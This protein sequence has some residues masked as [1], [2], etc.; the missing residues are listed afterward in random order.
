MTKGFSNWKRALEIFLQH[1]NSSMHKEAS[2]KIK[3]MQ[4]PT[5]TAQLSVQIQVDQKLHREK[6]IK[7]LT[8][9]RY[10]LRQGLA[11]RGHQPSYPPMFKYPK[12]NHFCSATHNLLFGTIR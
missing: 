6:L 3:L 12:F 9:M 11:L 5:V 4:Q 1:S 2:L 7:Q 10:L 8:T